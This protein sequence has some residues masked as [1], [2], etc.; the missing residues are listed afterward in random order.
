[1]DLT[2]TV[3]LVTGANRGL[4]R[5]LVEELLARGATRVY[6]AARDETSVVATD[7]RV[8]PIT[9][10]VT[11]RGQITAAAERATDVTLLINNAGVARFAD[12]IGADAAL[13]RLELETNYLGVWAMIEAFVPALERNGGGVATVLSLLSL[14]SMPALAGYSASKAAAHSLTQAIRPRLAA[15]GIAVHGIYPGAVDTDM[16]TDLEMPK[17]APRQVAAGILD[18]IAA[19]VEDIYPDPMSAQMSQLW[20]GDPKALERAFAGM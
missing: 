2:E 3:A 9:L 5:A 13:L 12:P 7:D 15:R 17:T 1:M 8:V 20:S 18:G 4:G 14:A 11:D 19:G 6:A 10:D 16:A